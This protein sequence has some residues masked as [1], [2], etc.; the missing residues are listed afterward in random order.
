MHQK[1]VQG[2]GGFYRIRPFFYIV[3]AKHVPNTIKDI[4][5][6]LSNLKDVYGDPL[7]VLKEGGSSLTLKWV[8]TTTHH[9]KLF[10]MKERS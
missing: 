4:E 6:A 1:K 2:G 7:R 3:A 5:K 8:S 10:Y 9:H